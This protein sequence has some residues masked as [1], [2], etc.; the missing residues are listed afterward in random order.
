MGAKRRSLWASKG[1]LVAACF[2]SLSAIRYPFWHLSVSA[3]QYPKG[4]HLTVYLD[5]VEGD[6][7]EVD[8]LNH[9][10]GMRSLDKAARWERRAAIPSAR[11]FAGLLLIAVLLHGWLR[12]AA[13]LPTL[14]FPAVFAGDLYWWLRDFGLHLDP[15]APLSSSVKPF[16]PPLLGAGKIAQFQASAG[17]SEGFYLILL[18]SFCALAAVFLEGSVMRKTARTAALAAIAVLIASP[19]QAAT[20]E[21]GAGRPYTHPRSALQA[22]SNGD[23]IRVH[24]GTYAGPLVV[25]KTVELRGEGMPVIDGG[26]KDSV[27]RIRSPHVLFKGFEVRGSGDVLNRDDAGLVASAE[28]V[29]V[30]NNHFRDVLFGVDLQRAPRSVVAGNRLEGKALPVARRGDLIRV[31]YSD[32][33]R[34]EGNHT[35]NGRDVVLWYSRQARVSGNTF[36]KGRYGLHFM[37]CADSIVEDNALSGNSVGAYLMYSRDLQLRGNRFTDNRGPSGFGIG[38]KDMQGA[39][40]EN[41]L[42]VGNRVGLFLDGSVGGSYERNLVAYND[43]GSQMLPSAQKNTFRTNHFVENDRQIDLDAASSQTI[44]DWEGNYWSDYRGYDMDGDGRGDTP[45]E[46]KRFFEQLT[47]RFHELRA[48]HSSPVVQALDYASSV[49]PIFEPKRDFTDPRPLSVPERLGA[50]ARPAVTPHWFFVSGLFLLPIA[51]ILKKHAFL[52]GVPGGSS[53]RLLRPVEQGVPRPAVRVQNLTKCF[54]KGVPVVNRVSLEVQPGEVVALWGPNGAGKTTLLRCLLGV[55]PFQGRVEIFG[56]DVLKEG[57]KARQNVGYVPQEIR[58]RPDQT[59]LEAVLFYARLRA[60]SD[61]RVEHLIREWGLWEAREQLAQNLSG[62]M[63]QRL[64]LAVALLS[65]PPL[66]FLDEPT[67]HLDSASRKEFIVLLSR[68]KASG[69]TLL[70]CSHRSSEILKIAD[71]VV[72]L[73][74]GSVASDGRPEKAEDL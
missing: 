9:Y 35:L 50:G 13:V 64:A 73:E 42:V 60:V 31:W 74:N 20:L 29:R 6:V 15:R 16:I 14:V 59:V 33:V 30:E 46:S 38:L 26:G 17:F 36:E 55:S 28:G 72:V 56:I 34:V 41:N 61:A 47:G 40:A 1:L 68:L 44:N 12:L 27:V 22:A 51:G 62:G 66:L 10:I 23:V 19:V 5:R 4:L 58:H 43:T 71:R 70:F 8:T 24:G 25:D 2:L 7:H 69:K 3:P 37:Y 39:V 65:D 49:F 53:A 18:A 54:S 21:V 45:Y 52:G 57:K 67:S 11:A 32:G 63:K 48:F